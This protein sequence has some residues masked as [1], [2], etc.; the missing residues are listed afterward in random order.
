M[1]NLKKCNEMKFDNLNICI[2]H[3]ELQGNADKHCEG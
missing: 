3:A 1:L 2:F